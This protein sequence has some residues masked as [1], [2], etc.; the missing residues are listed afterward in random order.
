MPRA[1]SQLQ[2]TAD[3]S[4]EIEMRQGYNN[5]KNSKKNHHMSSARHN[6]SLSTRTFLHAPNRKRTDQITAVENTKIVAS[7]HSGTRPGMI[8]ST[9]HN[10]PA[11]CPS[12]RAGKNVIPLIRKAM[13]DAA[14]STVPNLTTTT[15]KNVQAASSP[16]IRSPEFTGGRITGLTTFV[17]SPDSLQEW[18]ASDEREEKV[19]CVYR[20][21]RE[22]RLPYVCNWLFRDCDFVSLMPVFS[23]V[24]LQSSINIS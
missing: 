21:L 11:A 18:S 23:S 5:R 16:L 10:S 17:L 2:E 6:G 22:F 24:T 20:S 14:S 1:V 12:P 9:S 3:A 15:M 13:L 8:R 4:K 7:D 19:L